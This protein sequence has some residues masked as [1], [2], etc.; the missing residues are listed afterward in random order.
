VTTSGVLRPQYVESWCHDT[1]AGSA[2]SLIKKLAV[3]HSRSGLWRSSIASRM[4]LCRT[5]SASQVN[6]RCDLWRRSPLSGPL[7]RRSNSSSRPR[8]A[9]ASVSDMTRIGKTQPSSRYCSIWAGVRHFG[10]DPR[11]RRGQRAKR[12]TITPRTERPRST[13]PGLRADLYTQLLP[14]CV[15]W[16]MSH[17]I[18]RGILTPRTPGPGAASK[19]CALGWPLLVGTDVI[20]S[21]VGREIGRCSASEDLTGRTG[22]G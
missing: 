5:S 3:Q 8:S 1:K 19:R 20:A 22:G 11:N 14:H 4:E 2:A 10:I 6:S 15:N 13:L 21:K 9:A 12:I 7:V 18:A 17:R 16:R